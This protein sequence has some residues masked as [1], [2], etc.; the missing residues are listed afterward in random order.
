ME[1]DLRKVNDFV[2]EPST[3]NKQYDC[4]IVRNPL[5]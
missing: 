1:I 4:K 3:E 5:E 2:P